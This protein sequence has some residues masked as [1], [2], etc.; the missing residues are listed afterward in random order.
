MIVKTT[1]TNALDDC[2]SGAGAG[3]S[4]VGICPAKTVPESTQA[5]TTATANR[6]MCSPLKFED[7]SLLARTQNRADAKVVAGLSE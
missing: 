7:A 5:I 1:V 3:A 4:V 6:F 2:G